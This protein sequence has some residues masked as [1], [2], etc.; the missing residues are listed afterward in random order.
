[1]EWL[2]DQPFYEL[3]QAYRLAPAVDQK[4]VVNA[5]EAVKEAIRD[6]CEERDEWPDSRRDCDCD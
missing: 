3:M 2:D 5:F 4:A 1:M 6:K